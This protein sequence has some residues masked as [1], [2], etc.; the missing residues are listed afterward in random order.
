MGIIAL[1]SIA[2]PASAEISD[3]QALELANKEIVKFY[4][5][6]Q[7]WDAHIDKTLQDWRLTRD[8]W[9]NWVKSFAKGRAAETN[10]RIAEIEAAIK[11]KE[12]W[13]VVYNRKVPPGMR[14]RHTHAII[15]LNAENGEVLAV[16]NQEE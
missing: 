8:S 9:E 7:Q 16:I 12:V 4:V 11:G 15:F 1:T 6:L 5:D 2:V 3:N 14:I 13:L 10:A